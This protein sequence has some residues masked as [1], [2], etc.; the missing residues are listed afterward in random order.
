MN[1]MIMGAFFGTSQNAP[2]QDQDEVCEVNDITNKLKFVCS[3]HSLASL[4]LR[5]EC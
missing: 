2:V 3:F 1:N 5:R 4:E